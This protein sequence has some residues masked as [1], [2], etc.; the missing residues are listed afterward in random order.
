MRLT[1][2]VLPEMANKITMCSDVDIWSLA[3]KPMQNTDEKRKVQSW[4][5]PFVYSCDVKEQ[6]RI[7]ALY[8]W[9]VWKPL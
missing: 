2:Q 4:S 8:I 1:K 3:S 5:K 9:T 6:G 7:I